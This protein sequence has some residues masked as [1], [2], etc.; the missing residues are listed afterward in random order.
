MLEL[1]E[2][3]TV[4]RQMNEA[5]KGKR[6]KNVVL[7]QTPHRFAFYSEQKERYGAD[8]RRRVPAWRHGGA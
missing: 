8:D 1:P 3:R 5:L 6:V 4:A 7:E 2:S